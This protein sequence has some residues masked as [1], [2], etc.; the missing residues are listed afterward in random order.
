MTFTTASI[1]TD[2]NQILI[3]HGRVFSIK[4]QTTTEDTMGNVTDV[5]NDTFLAYGLIQD[6]TKKD[7]Q[8]HEMGLAVPGNVKAYF[9]QTYSEISGGVESNTQEIKERDI[10]VDNNN[11]Q[12]WRIEKI[13]GE[14]KQAL[15]VIVLKNIPNEG[16]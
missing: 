3:D 4:R 7:R 11:G 12:N 15:K 13:I 16:S 6:I 9:K 8:I 14:R 1:L 5:S 10:L 2:L